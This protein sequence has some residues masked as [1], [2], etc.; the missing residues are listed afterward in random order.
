M[1]RKRQMP[2][3]YP[4]EYQ[5]AEEIAYAKIQEIMYKAERLPYE[6]KDTPEGK[7]QVH[8]YYTEAIDLAFSYEIGFEA[9]VQCIGW[10]YQNDFD[11]EAFEAAQK[12][13]D[14]LETCAPKR[15]LFARVC[16]CLEEIAY[17]RDDTEELLDR[18]VMARVHNDLS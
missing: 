2:K 8:Q 17:E 18:I 15:K 9:V 4:A 6:V 3:W 16:D 11:D 12:L 1:G 13:F 10:L 14:L 5:C 7:E